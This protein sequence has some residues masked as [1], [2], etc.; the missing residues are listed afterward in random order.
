MRVFQ[1]TKRFFEVPPHW[2]G[3]AVERRER[4]VGRRRGAEERV[5]PEELPIIMVE[6]RK[7]KAHLRGCFRPDAVG[8][9][10]P[11]RAQELLVDCAASSEER[12]EV[13]AGSAL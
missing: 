7:L 1:S 11:N 9:V 2:D 12:W 5:L 4:D 13:D 3:R 8:E 10:D 6:R